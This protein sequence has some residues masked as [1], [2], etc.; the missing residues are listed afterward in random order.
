[1]LALGSTAPT[2][3]STSARRLRTRARHRVAAA[4]P[5]P[6]PAAPASEKKAREEKPL[7]AT[8][9]PDSRT[10]RLIEGRGLKPAEY[11]AAYHAAMAGQVRKAWTSKDFRDWVSAKARA[12]V[13]AESPA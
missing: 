3:A 10:R 8:W 9:E 4:A 12:R 2:A 11:L 1:M 5:A 7:P 6:A 13:G